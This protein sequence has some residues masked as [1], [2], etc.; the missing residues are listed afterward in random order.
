M[1]CF[2]TILS[3]YQASTI[4]TAFHPRMLISS[5][6]PLFAL[7]L[8]TCLTLAAPPQS[9][10]PAAAP[11]A[12]N[13]SLLCETVPDGVVDAGDCT[14]LLRH[15][16]ELAPWTHEY[17]TFGPP[18]TGETPIYINWRFCRLGVLAE[19]PRGKPAERFRLRDYLQ[20]IGL[21]NR[22]CL[23]APRTTWNAGTAGVGDKGI[24]YAYLGAVPPQKTGRVAH[25]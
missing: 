24:F 1:L 25:S 5:L 4:P 22:L 18:G 12:L 17:V 21:I 23:L 9:L 13:G 8:F 2:P 16:D 10:T 7:T 15:L 19:S 6:L 3:T 14:Y 11:Q 20:D